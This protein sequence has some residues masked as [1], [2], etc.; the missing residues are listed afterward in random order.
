MRAAIPGGKPRIL[1]QFGGR[2]PRFDD[3]A[4]DIAAAGPIVAVEK[5]YYHGDGGAVSF[6]DYTAGRVNGRARL[7]RHCS[8]FGRDASSEIAASGHLVAYIDC[9]GRVDGT[10]VVSD[11]SSRPRPALRLRTAGAFGRLEM[12]G[13][14]LAA[15][16]YATSRTLNAPWSVAVFDATNGAL[17]YRTDPDPRFRRYALGADGTLASVTFPPSARPCDGVVDWR[18]V[19]DPKPQRLPYRPCFELG[20]AAKRLVFEHRVG[21]RMQ[22]V[23]GNLGGGPPLP[24]AAAAAS[25]REFAFDGRRIAY[26]DWT[27]RGKRRI[28]VDSVAR[29]AARGPRPPDTCPIRFAPRAPLFVDGRGRLGA[30]VVCAHGCEGQLAVGNSVEPPFLAWPGVVQTVK[31]T[32]PLVDPHVRRR[33]YSVRVQ[34]SVSVQQPGGGEKKAVRTHRVI[35]NWLP[36]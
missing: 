28:V 1:M 15:Q 16:D 24:L 6:F 3:V 13:R 27:C 17:V 30:R 18:S 25:T 34:V 22:L 35:S 14:Y 7:V 8:T 4:L 5:E 31:L 9:G 11:L 33:P 26:G 32:R 12:A 20:L 23:M 36:S 21:S 10:V 19:S 29:I 2:L